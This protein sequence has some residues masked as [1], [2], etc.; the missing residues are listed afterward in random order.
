MINILD[1][2]DWKALY[3][4]LD[5]RG[6]ALT[7]PLLSERDCSALMDLNDDDSQF[8]TTVVMA[9]HQ[10]GNGEYRYFGNPIPSLVG[11]VRERFYAALAPVANGWSASLGQPAGFP[12]HFDAYQATCHQA[13]Q[14]RPTPLLLRY[15]SGGYNCL[16]Q[17]K[18][19][20]V[21]FPLQLTCLLSETDED[22]DGGEFL[23]VEN[24][25]RMQ[26]RGSAIRLQR[27]QCIIFPNQ[28]RPVLGKR[29]YYRVQVRHGV[30][31]IHRGIRMALG[32]IFHDAA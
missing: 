9:R 30:S 8:R 20:E 19:G 32:I 27:G 15:E 12:E 16:H 2:L 1:S 10:F 22:F 21:A 26:S 23:L 14:T 28:V 18:Y 13:G 11:R 31:T 17:D 29:G 4:S 6:Y 24:R 3:E 7:P 25:P 5:A